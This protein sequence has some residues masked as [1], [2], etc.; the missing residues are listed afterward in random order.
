M[1]TATAQ[2]CAD[3][4]C[5]DDAQWLLAQS[6]LDPHQLEAMLALRWRA[7]LD[8]LD[9]VQLVLQVSEEKVQQIVDTLLRSKDH[10]TVSEWLLQRD[11][12]NR[13]R[14]VKGCTPAHSGVTAWLCCRLHRSSLG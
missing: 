14:E 12:T 7:L 6:K 5:T 1:E 2:E 11:M 10:D 3:I 4:L 13:A 8:E 9:P